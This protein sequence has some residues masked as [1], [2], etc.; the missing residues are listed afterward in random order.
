MSD[1]SA[2]PFAPLWLILTIGVLAIAG[3]AVV[4]RLTGAHG[5]VV[6]AYRLWI[7]AAIALPTALLSLRGYR[8]TR[9]HLLL[10]ALSG[11]FLALH[12]ATWL[13]SLAYVSIAVSVTLTNTAPVWVALFTWVWL[14]QRPRRGTIIGISVAMFGGIIIAS[15]GASGNLSLTGALLALAGAVSV[16]GYLLISEQ[17]QQ[18]GVPSAVYIGLTYTAAAIAITPAPAIFNEPYSGYSLATY[19]WFA[20]LALGPQ[21]IG[22]SSLNY[23]TRFVSPTLV[24]TVTLLE[25]FGATVLAWFVFSELPPV[26]TIMGSAVL[27]VGLIITARHTRS[28]VVT[29]QAE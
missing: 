3:S 29:A 20:L 21:L 25:P 5:V 18:A 6:A 2:R 8:I 1:T 17:V 7:A 9:R 19:G 15:T 28:R 23:A 13:M 26:A 11:T 16:A 4:T 24:S 27:V 14:R 10:I 22:H 12:F